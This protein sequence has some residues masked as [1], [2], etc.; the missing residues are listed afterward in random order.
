M[1]GGNLS[2]DPHR[3]PIIPELSKASQTIFQVLSFVFN[4][5]V[6]VCLERHVTMGAALV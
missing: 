1:G 6:M 2:G 3:V 4:V 5:N